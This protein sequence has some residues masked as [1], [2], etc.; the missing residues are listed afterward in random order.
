MAGTVNLGAPLFLGN[1]AIEHPA[2]TLR[3]MLAA[4]F[5]P[6]SGDSGAE[7]QPGLLPGTS[8]HRG[9]LILT[10]PTA[11]QVNPFMAVVQGTHSTVQGAYVI[12]NAVPRSLAVTGRDGSQYRRSRLVVQV[13]DSAAAGVTPDA[14][15]DRAQLSLI[16]GALTA[17]AD[18]ALPATP[19]NSLTLGEVFIPPTS[20]SGAA[21][22]VTATAPPTA[23]RGGVL[24][25]DEGATSSGYVRWR[26]Q[27]R[28]HETRG[29]QR[30]STAGEYETVAPRQ[31]HLGSDSGADVGDITTDQAIINMTITVPDDL[32]PGRRIRYSGVAYC[33]W[34]SGVQPRLTFHGGRGARQINDTPANRCDLHIEYYDPDLTPG[35]RQVQ[36]RADAVGGAMAVHEPRL[37]ATIV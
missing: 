16:D 30:V 31:A 18:P 5:M 27:L 13:L 8:G 34:G 1:P 9:E 2:Q 12:P 7:V 35:S 20:A 28:D 11:L 6:P 19:D 26:G 4:L 23:L 15:N 32:P 25:V 21:V 33:V 10:S 29:L 3:Q 24:V 14:T 37:H 22:T 17:S 36:L